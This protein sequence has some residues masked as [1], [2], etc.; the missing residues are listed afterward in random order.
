MDSATKTKTILIPKAN[1]F[2]NKGLF[3]T[4]DNSRKV[5]KQEKNIQWYKNKK[6]RVYLRATFGVHAL[7]A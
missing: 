5:H 7:D 2:S 1:F 6:F 3:L 4:F